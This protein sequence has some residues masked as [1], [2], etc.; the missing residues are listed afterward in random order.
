[1]GANKTFGVT[2]RE[3]GRTEPDFRYKILVPR[4]PIL[5]MEARCKV[6]D[7]CWSGFM[8]ARSLKLLVAVTTGRRL[9]KMLR[10]IEIDGC[11]VTEVLCLA[12]IHECKTHFIGIH[13]C[14]IPKASR[15]VGAGWMLDVPCT[16]FC[17]DFG[18]QDLRSVASCEDLWR[19]HQWWAVFQG[20]LCMQGP[21][22]IPLCDN[23]WMPDVQGTTF[24]DNFYKCRALRGS[25]NAIS[26]KCR[27]SRRFLSANWAPQWV[28]FVENPWMHWVLL[29]KR[30]SSISL[31]SEDDFDCWIPSSMAETSIWLFKS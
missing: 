9:M 14:N 18:I 3:N 24:R 27:V 16:G 23:A 2:G 20:D 19:Q 6:L 30:R 1:M 25:V 17:R 15:F 28:Q 12:R 13:E 10:L 31:N 7:A 26:A 5:D 29:G 8:G 21:Q 4:F 11:N 22:S